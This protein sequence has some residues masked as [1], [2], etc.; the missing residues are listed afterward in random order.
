MTRPNIVDGIRKCLGSVPAGPVPDRLGIDVLLADAWDQFEGSDVYRTT[1]GKLRGRIENLTWS[2]PVLT[3]EIERH[4]GTVAGSSR[5]ELHSWS[6]DLEALTATC[7][8]GRHRQLYERERPLDVRPLVDGLVSSIE[9]GGNHESVKMSGDGT[10]RVLVSKIIPDT[11][12]KQTD[13]GRR[14]RFRLL[15]EQRLRDRG[16]VRAAGRAPYTYR[17]SE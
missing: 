9:T 11:G 16:W 10:I 3:F 2:P 4:G 12:A 7:W 14:K 13:A 17:R 6:V 1:A 15:L 5:A 8:T